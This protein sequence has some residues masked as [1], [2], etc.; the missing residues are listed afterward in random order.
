MDTVSCFTPPEREKWFLVLHDVCPGVETAKGAD[1][2]PKTERHDSE[3]RQLDILT[4]VG[5]SLNTLCC[6]HPDNRDKEV[7]K[8]TADGPEPTFCRLDNEVCVSGLRSS[9]E[10]LDAM[11]ERGVEGTPS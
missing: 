4:E 1:D 3:K 10:E 6:S 9:A 2:V 8:R 11:C 5:V 7:C